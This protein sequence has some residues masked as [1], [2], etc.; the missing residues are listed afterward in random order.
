MTQSPVKSRCGFVAI[1]G[2]PNAGKST[3]MNGALGEKIAI[4]TP[5]VQTTRMNMRGILTEGDTQ[6]VFVDTPGIH[7]PRRQFDKAMVNAAWQASSDADAVLL[8]VDAQKGFNGDVQRILADIAEVKAPKILVL[9]K[10][11][12]MPRE[13]LLPL[14][15]K[16]GAMGVFDHI[17]AISALKNDRIKDVI[18]CLKGY[19]PEEPFHYDPEDLTDT[20]MRVIAAEVTRER[21]FML[22]GDEIPYSV[23]VETVGYVVQEDGS[24]RIDQNILLERDGQKKIVIGKGGSM[25]KKIGEQA[26]KALSEMTGAEVHLFLQVKVREGWASDPHLMRSLGL[27]DK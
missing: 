27:S 22:L 16:A 7:K 12:K 4:V 25:L 6:M 17:F 3:F 10:V 24:I 15:G 18:K 26:R 21:A 14:M 8:L 5:K 20:P 1:I 13:K 19:M 2:A 11:D 9:N 23:N